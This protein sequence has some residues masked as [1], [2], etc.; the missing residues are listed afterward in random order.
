MSKRALGILILATALGCQTGGGSTSPG[1]SEFDRDSGPSDPGLRSTG[2][3]GGAGAEA[4]LASVY[5]AFDQSTLRG[6]ARETL[7]R[8]A[9]YL[10]QHGD[11]SVEIQGNCDERG[12]DEYNLALG[13]RRADA[14]KRYLMDLG[15]DS[16]RL[17]TISFGE[18]N[19]AIR[20][21]NEAAWAKNRRGDF[22]TR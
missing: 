8:N 7:R 6:D 11:V 13:M 10:S 15:V 2:S 4:S 5:F 14:A 3:R 20:G 9:D 1:T 16:G 21:H 18:E 19:P 17:G 22:V 12:S